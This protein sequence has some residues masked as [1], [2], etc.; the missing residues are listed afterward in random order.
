MVASEMRGAPVGAAA[1]EDWTDVPPP[2]RTSAALADLDGGLRRWPLWTRMAWEDMRQKYRRSV[3]GPFWLSLSMLVM[4][5]CLGVLYSQIFNKPVSEYLPYL[6]YGLLFWNLMQEIVREGC[7][8][9]IMYEGIIR[10]IRLPLSAHVYRLTCRHIIVFGHNFIVCAPVALLVGPW[11][12]WAA[13]LVLPGFVLWILNALWVA[14]LFGSFSA[15]F[16]DVPPLIAS[17]LQI[18]FFMSP[19]MW[20]P[21][22]LGA[23]AQLVEIDPVYHFIEIVRAPLLGHV[24]GAHS[25]LFVGAVTLLGWGVTFPFFARF[26]SRISYWL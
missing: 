6:S 7:L 3:L 25:W 18:V 12:G 15:R 10:Q 19:I 8:S 14:L 26:R 22:S 21:S 17:V 9:F 23:R 4:I 5:G 1:V 24:P 13:L 11:P 16:R 20:E 2:S